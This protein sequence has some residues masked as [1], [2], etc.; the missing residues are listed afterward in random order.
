VPYIDPRDSQGFER[1]GAAHS[2]PRHRYGDRDPGDVALTPI[3]VEALIERARGAPRAVVAWEVCEWGGYGLPSWRWERRWEREKA[4]IFS[5]A[6]ANAFA[7][8]L[9]H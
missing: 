2:A 1:I 9:M 5:A 8:C 6:C 7:R 4:V 3:D